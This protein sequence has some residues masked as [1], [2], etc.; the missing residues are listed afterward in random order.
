LSFSAY[1]VRAEFIWMNPQVGG[2]DMH[3]GDDGLGGYM[4]LAVASNDPA[5]GFGAA[6]GT[7]QLAWVY[8]SHMGVPIRY[9]DASGNTLPMPTSYSVP[10]FPGQ[11]RTSGLAVADLYYNMHR[12]YDSSTGRYIQAD[13]IGLDGGPSPYSYAMNNP[14]RYMD[15]EG[16]K[17]LILFDEANGQ[18]RKGAAAECARVDPNNSATNLHVFS[19]GNTR[20]IC[21]GGGVC[22]S[23]SQFYKENKS[24]FEAATSTTLWGCSTG[25]G[26]L[27]V[28]QD[29]A[30][31]TR[32]PVSAYD[33]ETWWNSSGFQGSAGTQP[34]LW[35]RLSDW[36]SG[37][38]QHVT[39][40]GRINHTGRNSND[41]GTRRNFTP[42]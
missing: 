26:D 40:N 4:P 30:D 8:A 2:A 7:S 21:V 37:S 3:G 10:G 19:H 28:A 18:F 17:C 6:G 27:N 35:E 24:H 9:S 25:R 33:R 14:L 13:P 41:P 39:R 22:R 11:S 15:P 16:L 12:D 32:K 31:L 38:E 36:W 29:L 23:A 34:T 1:D 20:Q 5:S 42:Q